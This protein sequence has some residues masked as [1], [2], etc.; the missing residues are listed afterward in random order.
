[1]RNWNCITELLPNMY[2][3][4]YFYL[5]GGSVGDGFLFSL[6]KSRSK[7]LTLKLMLGF[8]APLAHPR[9]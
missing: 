2:S 8:F 3:A 7:R 5:R 4:N 6:R 9:A 1:M